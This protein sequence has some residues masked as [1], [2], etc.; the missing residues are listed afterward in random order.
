M[1]NKN[2]KEVSRSNTQGL[3]PNNE[4]IFI[5]GDGKNCGILATLR[6]ELPAIAR[7]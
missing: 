7:C 1:L 6:C 4:I 5:R 3:Y 2:E